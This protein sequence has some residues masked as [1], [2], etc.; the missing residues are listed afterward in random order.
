MNS[1][2]NV[3]TPVLLPSSPHPHIGRFKGFKHTEESRAK[4][5]AS[6]KAAWAR[7]KAN[8]FKP[9]APTTLSS[10]AYPP[11]KTE[12][13]IRVYKEV[14]ADTASLD[15][16]SYTPAEN[17]LANYVRVLWQFAYN[18]GVSAEALLRLVTDQKPK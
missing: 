9:K 2:C 3:A 16:T 1:N 18:A 12:E 10:E 6:L 17:L 14:H 13:E 7:R 4:M 5:R 8:G 11:Q 15:R